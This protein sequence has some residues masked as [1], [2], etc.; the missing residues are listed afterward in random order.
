MNEKDDL[1]IS[2]MLLDQDSAWSRGDATGFSKHMADGFLATNVQGQSMSGKAVF[3]RQHEFIF[4]GFFKGSK[5]TQT[6][7]TLKYLTE[8]TAFVETTVHVSNLTDPPAMWPL[9]SQGQLETRLLQVL[10]KSG[11]TWS[12]VAYHNTIVNHRAPPIVE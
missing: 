2:S 6:I 8:T 7:D 5:M 1:A 12:V 10:E 11:G 4:G 9:D 3:D